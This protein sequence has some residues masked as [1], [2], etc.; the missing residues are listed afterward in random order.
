MELYNCT[1]HARLCYCTLY[2]P[3][4]CLHRF[5][6]PPPPNATRHVAANIVMYVCASSLSTLSH[7]LRARH[8]LRTDLLED[9][10][11]CPLSHALRARYAL[12][13]DLLRGTCVYA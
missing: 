8:A 4:L 12:R 10:L 11:V 9:V 7:A 1:L 13:T 2:S 3:L 6:S 5:T